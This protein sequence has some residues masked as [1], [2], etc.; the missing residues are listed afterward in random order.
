M[1]SIKNLAVEVNGIRVLDSFNL[2]V[3]A[4][5]SHA[6]MGPNGSGKSSLCFALLGHPKYKIVDGSMEFEGKDLRGMS[7]DER[8]KLGIFLGFQHPQEISGMTMGNFLRQTTNIK[9]QSSESGPEHYGPAEYYPVAKA[10]MQK[11]GL[12][13]SF[14]G[15]GINEGFSGG[16]KKR[17]ELAQL[18]ALIPKLALLDEIDSGLDVDALRQV[19]EAVELAKKETGMGLILI[20][21]YQRLLHYIPVDKVHL[22]IGGKVVQTGGTE[23]V[24]LV[25]KEGYKQ[26]K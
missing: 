7:T 15:R 10:M 19:A 12:L 2:E 20:T 23:L 6:I 3:L 17:S 18:L 1:L 5:E 16:E 24:E 13:E 11:V 22:L 14:I 8:S 21:H 9:S 26:W 4:G 25:E